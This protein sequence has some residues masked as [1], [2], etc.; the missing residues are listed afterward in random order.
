MILYYNIISKKYAIEEDI[1]GQ[2][3]YRLNLYSASKSMKDCLWQL[4][5]YNKL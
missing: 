1:D 3:M 5:S 2:K 4:R